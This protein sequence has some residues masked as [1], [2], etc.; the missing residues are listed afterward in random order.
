MPRTRAADDENMVAVLLK[1]LTRKPDVCRP[2]AMLF[3][4]MTV[5]ACFGYAAVRDNLPE[6]WA[7]YGGGIPYVMFW[8]S[9]WFLIFPFRNCVLTICIGA[10]LVTCGLEFLQLWQPEWLVKIRSTRFGAALLGSGFV[11][12]DFPPYFI[13]GL[14]GYLALI[15]MLKFGANSESCDT[16][17]PA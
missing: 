7:G 3:C 13:G 14:L 5:V 6:W 17:D 2:V 12:K 15:G 10:T 9:V 11:W 4:A 8:I 16:V 1:F